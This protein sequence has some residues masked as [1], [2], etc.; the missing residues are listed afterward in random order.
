M[1]SQSIQSMI[2][3]SSIKSAQE[4]VLQIE[5]ILSGRTGAVSPTLPKTDGAGNE[6]NLPKFSDYM[7][8]TPPQGLKYKVAELPSLSKGQ[9]QQL[10][11]Q[12]SE[13]YKI[14]NKLV[15]A[16][17]QQESNFNTSAVSK[18][19]AMGLMQLMPATAKTL[20]V[21]NPFSAEQNIEGGVKHLKNMLDK[22]KGNLILA[23]AAYNAGGGSVDKYGGVPPYAETQNYVRKILTNYLG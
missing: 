20:G 3:S 7:K 10:V 17:I 12:I 6:A 21:L 16:V 19:G 13:K 18:A 1:F 14:D 9:I 5:S 11:S 23:L 4:R 15:M 8:L 2:Q 22:Y